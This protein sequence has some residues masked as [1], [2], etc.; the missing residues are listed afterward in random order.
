[1]ALDRLKQMTEHVTATSPPPF[2]LDPL[3]STEIERAV[4]LVVKEHGKLAFNAVTVWEPKKKEMLAWL[5]NPDVA[6]KPHRIADVVG[7]G[8][9]GFLYDGLV[10]LNENKII[11][12]ERTEDAQPLVRATRMPDREIQLNDSDYHG[13]PPDCRARCE[14]RSQRH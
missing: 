14:G 7:I 3:S 5:A 6:P 9:G 13:R 12:W 2:P 4:R 10:D 1:M 8:K 11:K